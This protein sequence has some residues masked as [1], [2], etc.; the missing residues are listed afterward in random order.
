MCPV[1]FSVKTTADLRRYSAASGY[2]YGFNPSDP[3]IRCLTL[4]VWLACEHLLR[5]MH[6]AP[7]PVFLSPNPKAELYLRSISPCVITL[8]LQSRI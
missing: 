6:L 1:H 7:G 8:C 3:V 2:V 5:S 4:G